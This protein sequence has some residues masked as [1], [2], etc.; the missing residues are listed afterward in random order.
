MSRSRSF[1][2]RLHPAQLLGRPAV[3]DLGH[4]VAVD[5]ERLVPVR[6]ALVRPRVAV[7]LEHPVELVRPQLAAH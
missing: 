4:P 1:L 5:Q 6:P 7:A 2:E 3:V